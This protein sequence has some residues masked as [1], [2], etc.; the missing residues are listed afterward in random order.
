VNTVVTFKNPKKL[1]GG[2][3]EMRGNSQAEVSPE[4]IGHTEKVDWSLPT[5]PHIPLIERQ[6]STTKKFTKSVKAPATYERL[7]LIVL[8]TLGLLTLGYR[9]GRAVQTPPLVVVSSAAPVIAHTV[10]PG[11]TLWKI[12]KKYGN[13]ETYILERVAALETLNP[14]VASAPLHVGSTVRVRV[15]NPVLVAQMTKHLQ[16]K[17]VALR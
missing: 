17:N 5:L 7:T 12:A 6:H 3:G 2:L 11:D 4:I 10:K 13:P 8:A 14:E 16:S 9:A 15:E 1:G